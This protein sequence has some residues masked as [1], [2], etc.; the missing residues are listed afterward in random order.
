MGRW[1]PRRPVGQRTTNRLGK[2]LT[3]LAAA[4]AAPVAP[5]ASVN[6]EWTNPVSGNWTDGTKWSTTPNDPNNGTPSGVTYQ[7]L[8]DKV[9]PTPYSVT[10]NGN[11]TIDSLSLSASNATLSH[12]S[13]T[14]TTSGLTLTAGTYQLKGGKVSGGATGATVALAAGSQF[15]LTSGTLID[16]ASPEAISR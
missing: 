4:I 7:A 12:T 3:A 9:G 14:L 1:E 11:I 16:S 8:I 2:V 5:A 15:Q 10:L 13:G 6:S